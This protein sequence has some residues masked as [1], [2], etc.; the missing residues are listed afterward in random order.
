MSVTLITPGSLLPVGVFKDI[1]SNDLQSRTPMDIIM[2]FI[3]KK[4]PRFETMDDRVLV[5][6]APTGAGKSSVMAEV[7]YRFYTKLDKRNIY[8]SQPRV[9]NA[10]NIVEELSGIPKYASSLI[11]FETIGYITGPF[12]LGVRGLNLITAGTLAI[13]LRLNTDE[14]ILDNMSMIIIDEAHERSI[15]TDQLFYYVKK[16]LQR[17][18]GNARAPFLIVMSA[19]FKEKDIAHYLNSTNYGELIGSQYPIENNFAK[20]RPSNYLVSITEQIIELIKPYCTGKMSFTGKD[21]FIIFVPGALEIKSIINFINTSKEIT[22]PVAALQFSSDIAGKKNEDFYNAIERNADEINATNMKGKAKIK[23][24]VS[25]SA[26]ETGV[27]IGTLK[28]CIDY[29]RN[30]SSNFF[31]RYNANIMY[32]H[33]ASQDII[34]QRRGRVGRKQPGFW[35]PQ[36][37]EN[38]FLLLNEQLYP[39]IL[40]SDISTQLLSLGLTSA[41]IIN[42]EFNEETKDNVRQP[43]NFKSIDTLSKLNPELLE[44]YTQKFYMLGI[45]DTKKFTPLGYIISRFAKTSIEKAKTILSSYVFNISPIIMIELMAVLTMLTSKGGE[46]FT[47]KATKDKEKY[48]ETR[49]KLFL[50]GIPEEFIDEPKIFLKEPNKYINKY[51]VQISDELIETYFIYRKI[52]QNHKKVMPNFSKFDVWCEK[53]GINPDA[54]YYYLDVRDEMIKEVDTVGFNPFEMCY[55]HDLH[56]FVRK[57]KL[58]LFEGYKFNL[59]TW[60]DGTYVRRN[61]D[62][63]AIYPKY[64]NKY[65]DYRPRGVLPLVLELKKIGQDDIFRLEGNV[66]STLDGYIYFD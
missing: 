27:T 66:V 41:N 51:R 33:P 37:I 49:N 44:Y 1:P 4:L 53:H 34:M 39:D 31:P 20:A 7:Y 16:L 28:Y 5:L 56:S 32:D 19:T 55:P 50:E 21:D 40:I 63:V 3:E 54:F 59:T 14:K 58:C 57:V 46:I 65:E 22:I 25:T 30:R 8:G 12:K 24:V 35:Y 6:K 62:E 47:K 48:N 42:F 13:M 15:D 23:L 9:T 45:I 10:V 11:K 60:K 17:N 29:G 36:Y 61:G 2:E 64:F 26:I 43:H 38:D 18:I 52:M